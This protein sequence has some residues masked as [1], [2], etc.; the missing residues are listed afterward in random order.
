MA[1]E[2]FCVFV[3]LANFSRNTDLSLRSDIENYIIGK[4]KR[5]RKKKKKQEKRERTIKSHSED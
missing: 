2:S 4:K 5:E 1:V 3:E